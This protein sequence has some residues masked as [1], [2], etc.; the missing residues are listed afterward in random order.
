ML[1][2]LVPYHKDK[3]GPN[4]S[5]YGIKWNILVDKKILVIKN[6]GILWRPQIGSKC[7]GMPMLGVRPNF[8]MN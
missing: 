5:G 6:A 4:V 2:L 1:K 7:E 3:V 8:T